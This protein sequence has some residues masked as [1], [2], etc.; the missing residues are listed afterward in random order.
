MNIL[1][2]DSFINLI[3]QMHVIGEIENDTPR[4]SQ[5]I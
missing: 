3:G 4:V 5:F 2:H 1:S